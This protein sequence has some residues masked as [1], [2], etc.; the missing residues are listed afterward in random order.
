MER[1]VSTLEISAVRQD[2]ALEL[3]PVLLEISAV[4]QDS[5]LEISEPFLA[6][7][8]NP[9]REIQSSP[10]ASYHRKHGDG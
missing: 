1:T 5:A 9:V 10:W 6:G 4:R 2:S 7:L 8:S 3:S